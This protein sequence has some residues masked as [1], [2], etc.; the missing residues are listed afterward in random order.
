MSTDLYGVRILSIAPD[1]L[2]ARLRVFVVYYDTHD[3]SHAPLP[4]DP[5]FFFRVLW[6]ATRERPGDS[7]HPLRMLDTDQVLE[8]DWVAANSHRYV[9]RI[10]QVATRNHPV[11]P[12]KWADLHDFYYERKGAWQDEDLLVQADYDVEVTDR[13]WLESLR[14][15]DGWGTTSYPTDSD[16]IPADD[17]PTVLDLREPALT[18][19]VFAGGET[20]AGTP[21]DL[22]FSD[23]GQYLAMTSQACEL[24]VLRTD[25]W[26]EHARVADSALWGQDI[27]WVPGTHRI[28]GRV[29]EGGGTL[30]D[31]APT[32]AYDVDTGTEVDVPP[33]PREA[34]SRTGRYRVDGS[35]DRVEVLTS[36]GTAR[37][38]PLPGQGSVSDVCFTGDETRMFARQGKDVHVLDPET[39]HALGTLA[40]AGGPAVV[41]P[42]GEYVAACGPSSATRMEAR[43]IDLWRVSDGELLMRCRTGGRYLSTLTWSPDGSMLAASVITGHE[44]YGGGVRIYRAGPPVEPPAHVEPTAADVRKMIKN[45]Y[46][47][48]DLVFLYDRLAEREEDP[49]AVGRAYRDKATVLRGTGDL[50]GAAEALRRAVES[51]GI[52]DALHASHELASVL[53]ELREYDDAVAAART[54]Y[55]MAAE[56]DLDRPRHRKNLVR[57]ATGF[58][59][60]LH[61][62]GAD[63][64]AD[65]E[66]EARAACR[67]ALAHD[68]ADAPGAPGATGAGEPG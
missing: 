30:D 55:R 9:R 20:D 46:L 67:R 25:D 49:A 66:A 12:K 21:S 56:R 10:K 47:P 64:D 19:D 1:A 6:E 63:G 68:T 37:R 22:A 31:E 26:S 51:G 24:V 45:T 65:E 48:R 62:R 54:A 15:G 44:G 39:G 40:V 29:I 27:Q 57:V 38:L 43:L 41:R 8:P 16:Q 60:I 59:D 28:T 23:D 36:S 53:V 11:L 52:S 61:A 34:R 13:R 32:R 35:R 58:A 50:P 33:Q 17:A 18:L 4:H 2:S 14:P 5:S 3:R 42:D 7:F